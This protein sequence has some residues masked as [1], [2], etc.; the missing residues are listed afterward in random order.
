MRQD[1]PPALRE[2]RSRDPMRELSRDAASTVRAGRSVRCRGVRRDLQAAPVPV[3]V[4]FWAPWCGPCRMMAPELETAARSMA[5]KRARDQ[6]QHGA[7][8]ELGER[9]RILSIPTLAVFRGGSEISRCVGR[10]AR[11][12]DIEAL[13][14]DSTRIARPAKRWARVRRRQSR[15]YVRTVRARDR[16][17]ADRHPDRTS[18]GGSLARSRAGGRMPRSRMLTLL[19]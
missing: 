9:F 8:P 17:D 4:D 12:P 19:C 1:E 16:E 18:I 14:A 11:R 3:V 15:S 6:S 2:S 5:G 13:V 7:V 10:E